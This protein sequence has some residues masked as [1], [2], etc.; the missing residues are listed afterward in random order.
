MPCAEWCERMLNLGHKTRNI[1]QGSFGIS[2]WMLPSGFFRAGAAPGL[3]KPNF[4]Q[5]EFCRGVSV[6]TRT[7][8]RLL[9]PGKPIGNSVLRSGKGIFLPLGNLPAL[10]SAT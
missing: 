3:V 5:H 4:S 10:F 6:S 8:P 1:Y 7:L 9:R 2:Q